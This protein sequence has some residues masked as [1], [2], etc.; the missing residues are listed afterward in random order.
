MN[1]GK[2]ITFLYILMR[3]ELTPGKVETLVQ[4]V[5]KIRNPIKFSNGHLALYAKEL[6]SR[7]NND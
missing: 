7:M 1:E 3:D 6:L 4:A 2:L 5:E